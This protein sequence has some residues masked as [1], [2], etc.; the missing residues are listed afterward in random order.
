[1]GVSYLHSVNIVHGDLCGVS[2]VH[3]GHNLF[4]PCVTDF[5]LAAFIELETS[6][7]SSTHGGSTRWMAPD[8]LLLNVYSPDL[9]FCRTIESDVWAFTCLLRGSLWLILFPFLLD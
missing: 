3:P 5:G 9:S 2:V 4:I 7:K 6:I 8:L 1:M